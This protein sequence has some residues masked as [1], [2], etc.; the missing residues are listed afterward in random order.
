VLW[1][2][3]FEGG[4][5][6]RLE[7]ER[8]S[9]LIFK[10]KRSSQKIDI[11]Y[12]SDHPAYVND[13]YVATINFMVRKDVPYFGSSRVSAIVNELANVQGENF[14]GGVL[15]PKPC[16]LDNLEESSMNDDG[17]ITRSEY[18]NAFDVL[19]KDKTGFITGEEFGLASAAPFD[20]LD[21]DQDEE[22]TRVEYEA[23]FD[24]AS[25]STEMESGIVFTISREHPIRGILAASQN[26][27][28]FNMPALA[29]PQH[30]TR[31]HL[32]VLVVRENKVE[33]VPA[34]WQDDTFAPN[35]Q[36]DTLVCT[37]SEPEAASTRGCD[38]VLTGE[39]R[40]GSG[41]LVLTVRY[42]S[43]V[44]GSF[45][46]RVY[47]RV[48]FPERV[49]VVNP[50]V[51]VGT[52]TA[53]ELG[54]QT[55]LTLRPVQDWYKSCSSRLPTFQRAR[56]RALATFSL[57]PDDEHKIRIDVTRFVMFRDSTEPSIIDIEGNVIS[58]VD[59][60]LPESTVVT[61]VAVSVYSFATQN[62]PIRVTIDRS[63]SVNIVDLVSYLPAAITLYPVNKTLLSLFE[64]ITFSFGVET[65]NL[66]GEGDSKTIV[67]YAIFE[68]G[69]PMEITPM[70][71]LV[72][73]SRDTTPRALI[74][75]LV[76]FND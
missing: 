15:G 3:D 46:A 11:L 42:Q 36:G 51:G 47:F 22:L 34:N 45:E 38:V 14:A 5:Y 23:G 65:R 2:R 73:T 53:D 64:D 74:N 52:E 50:W 68:V 56:I 62:V 48:W 72:L 24:Q 35:W 71:G 30:E 60:A 57:G 44:S 75:L 13:M 25:F 58:V 6:V 70:M 61:D 16:R 20:L 26:I 63:S 33:E 37:T 54:Y 66:T 27:E 12:D 69:Q 67:T 43:I 17:R 28:L 8:H 1:S 55:E 76:V 29:G 19:D 32:T 7:D 40:V 41:N 9:S 4:S 31:A 39:E 21:K 10:K 18:N 49:F 59:R